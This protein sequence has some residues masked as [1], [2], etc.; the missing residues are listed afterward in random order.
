MNLRALKHRCLALLFLFIVSFCLLKAQNYHNGFARSLSMDSLLTLEKRTTSTDSLNHIKFAIGRKYGDQNPRAQQKYKELIIR[1]K[2]QKNDELLHE[3]L[4][5]SSVENIVNRNLDEAR[6]KL[7]QCVDYYRKDT[8]FLTKCHIFLGYLSITKQDYGLALEHLRLAED[9]ALQDKHYRHLNDI[10]NRSGNLYS[11]LGK[12]G[13][14]SAYYEKVLE[15]CNTHGECRLYI[16]AVSNLRHL[17]GKRNDEQAVDSLEKVII[18]FYQNRK[19][20]GFRFYKAQYEVAKRN[21]QLT[22]QVAYLDTMLQTAAKENS[23]Y[24]LLQAYRRE[25]ELHYQVGDVLKS[26]ESLQ[27]GIEISER[28]NDVSGRVEL[29]RILGERYGEIGQF[30]NSSR[31]FT[32]AKKLD[33]MNDFDEKVETFL[34]Y[35]QNLALDEREKQNQVLEERNDLLRKES[36]RKT[37]NNVQLSVLSSLLGISAFFL[38]LLLRNRQSSNR[39]LKAQNELIDANLKEKELLLREIHHRVKN[40]LQMV[41][42]L[43]S[44]QNEYIDD[45]KVQNAL[46]EGQN[47]INTISLIHQNLFKEDILHGIHTDV[48]LKRLIEYFKKNYRTFDLNIDIFHQLD[49]VLLSVDEMI[50]LGLISNELLTNSI[51]HAFSDGNGGTINVLLNEINGKVNFKYMDSGKG[52]PEKDD[53]KQGFGTRMI[54]AFVKKLNGETEIKHSSGYSFDLHFE[55]K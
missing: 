11:I 30:Q 28:M 52:F 43:L 53:L 48:Y 22:R 38:V 46:Q 41:S 42:G 49:K 24:L 32:L 7:D 35:E 55:K 26:I 37:R 9:L 14:A 47:R 18:H 54:S 39:K 19:N 23:N 25:A 5:F 20:K 44:I 1:A 31:R 34:K 3:T 45:D 8:F 21:G 17:A 29:L 51:K 12:N 2:A 16:V 27:K 15:N 13:Q 40:N 50:C 33:A 10:Y 4:L 6:N 36:D